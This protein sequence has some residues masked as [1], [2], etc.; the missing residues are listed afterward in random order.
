MGC[1]QRTEASRLD[2][3]AGGGGAEQGSLHVWVAPVPQRPVR[4]LDDLGRRPPQDI[5]GAAWLV[6]G[7]C[8]KTALFVPQKVQQLWGGGRRGGEEQMERT[9]Q[10]TA[11]PT[12][13]RQPGLPECLRAEGT[14]PAVG[15][16]ALA[17]GQDTQAPRVPAPHLQGVSERRESTVEGTEQGAGRPRFWPRLCHQA[18][19]PLASP[20]SSPSLSFPICRQEGVGLQRPGIR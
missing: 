8:G 2:G 19:G 12:L 5:V 15:G 14:Q 9:G 11:K 4:L 3:R 1:S 17:S 10:Q 13:T 16:Q 20:C 18:P 7:P 6:V